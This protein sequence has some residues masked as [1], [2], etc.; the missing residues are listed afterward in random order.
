[1]RTI[2]I[3]DPHNT[4]T[5]QS[6]LV[7]NTLATITLYAY[8]IHTT[9]SNYIWYTLS[10]AVPRI[11]YA[12]THMECT[13][14]THIHTKS[15]MRHTA[16]TRIKS[17]KWYLKYLH[18]I[19]YSVVCTSENCLVWLLCVNHQT[20]FV[21]YPYNVVF[22]LSILSLYS[23]SLF[24]LSILS[25]QYSYKTI[26]TSTYHTVIADIFFFLGGTRPRSWW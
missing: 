19:N 1:M 7:H 15:Y 17:M 21:P 6:S 8:H 24:S 22:S 13:P 4:H 10:L 16:H 11:P 26:F 2:S 12:Y 14:F 9:V 18:S 25:T 3:Q 23:L 5:K 20:L